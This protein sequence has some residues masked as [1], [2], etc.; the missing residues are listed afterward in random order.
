MD[1]FSA[2]R[3]GEELSNSLCVRLCYYHCRVTRELYKSSRFQSDDV[4]CVT[5]IHAGFS[6]C[7]FCNRSMP[8]CNKNSSLSLESELDKAKLLHLYMN[9]ATV[10]VLITRD[11]R[12]KKAGQGGGHTACEFMR[13]LFA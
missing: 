10:R 12:G 5:I 1:N 13:L 9:K 4:F 3:Q 7:R 11:L 6:V 8:I 2:S